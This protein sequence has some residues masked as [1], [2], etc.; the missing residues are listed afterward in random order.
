MER[1]TVLEERGVKN[2]YKA[3]GCP[4]CNYTGYRGRTAL[5]E[6]LFADK[7]LR[8]LIFSDTA[9]DVIRENY[10]KWGMRDLREQGVRRVEAGETT[11]EELNAVVPATKF[12][13]KRKIQ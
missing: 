2:V 3:K 11:L 7:E 12:F 4:K 10:A 9:P 1:D 13:T 5:F 8:E 6:I